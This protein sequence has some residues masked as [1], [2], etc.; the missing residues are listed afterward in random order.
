MQV[1]H[2]SN[3]AEVHMMEIRCDK[4]DRL[5]LLEAYSLGCLKIIIKSKL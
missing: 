4:A 5:I 3:A 1:K 2:F